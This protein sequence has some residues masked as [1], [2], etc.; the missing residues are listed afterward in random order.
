MK[1]GFVKMKKKRISSAVIAAI[2]LITVL[3]LLCAGCGSDKTAV[4]E[5]AVDEKPAASE[6]NDAAVPQADGQVLISE[7]DHVPMASL[8]SDYDKGGSSGWSGKVTIIEDDDVAKA[9]APVID[10]QGQEE[11]AGEAPAKADEPAFS[12]E[13]TDIQDDVWID[14][15]EDYYETSEE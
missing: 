9:D 7:N 5:K 10:D 8:P 11:A 12:D 1:Y 14:I 15:F 4:S 6:K 3:M 2:F 13:V